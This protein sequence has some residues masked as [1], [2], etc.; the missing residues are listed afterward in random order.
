MEGPCLLPHGRQPQRRGPRRD[1]QDPPDV[2]AQLEADV[3]F[4]QGEAS[5]YLSL[6]DSAQATEYLNRVENFYLLHR[7][8]APAGLELQ[9]AWLLYNL[10][11]DKELYPVLQALDTRTDLTPA[12]REQISTLW[13]NFAVRRAELFLD[14]GY[15]LRGV[16]ILQAASED[17]PDNITV[18]SAVAGAYAKVGRPDDALALFKT[19][20]MDQAS[21]GDYQWRHRCCPRRKRHVTGRSM[22]PSRPGSLP[23]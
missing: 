21:A 7:G 14:S 10:G 17:Y 6:G 11:N 19:I 23:Q 4:E 3:E 2:R 12:Q 15:L 20:P 8:T 18:R 16:Q 13:A 9:H 1:Q 5:L 22:A